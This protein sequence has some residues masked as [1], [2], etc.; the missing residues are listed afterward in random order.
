MSQYVVENSITEIANKNNLS[1][2]LDAKNVIGRFA[3]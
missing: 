3:K 2:D 1:K